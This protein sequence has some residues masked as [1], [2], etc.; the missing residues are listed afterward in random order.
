MRRLG[1]LLLLAIAA[2]G[3]FAAWLDPKVN[4]PFKGY[5][6]PSIFVDIP[7]GTS[8][9]EAAGI[10]FKS[11]VVRN[12]LGFEILVRFHQRFPLQAGEYLFD[13][14]MSGRE[15]FWKIAE[16]RIYVQKVT[17]R[18]GWTIFDIA[19]ELEKVGVMTQDEFLRVARDPTPILDLA[20]HA[21]SLEGF[22]FPS[23]Y[24]FT[25]HVTPEL[26][27]GTMIKQF[28]KEWAAL[29]PTEDPPLPA[30]L[31]ISQLVTVASLVERETP[32]PEERPVVAGVFY[33]RLKRNEPLQCDPTVQYALAL[34]GDIVRNITHEDLAIGSPYNT[35]KHSGLPPGPIANPGEIALRAAIAPAQTDYLYFVAN[36][37]GGHFFSRTLAEHNRNVARYRRLL[38]E[39]A[40]PEDSGAASRK[41]RRSS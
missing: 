36:D 12:R 30:G 13:R 11:G 8:R 32:L 22:L 4:R 37:E 20:P 10:L 23:S 21:R 24:E 6:P 17:V 16:G 19:D 31:D 25:R 3:G 27:A 40:P 38:E 5:H 35:Y 2:A 14:P 1:L 28:R 33:N 18:E 29:R 7:K 9:W 39:S 15:V 34:K 26:V 41:H